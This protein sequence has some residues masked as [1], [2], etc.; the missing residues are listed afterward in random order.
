M[1]VAPSAIRTPNSRVRCDTLAAITPVTPASV[2]TIARPAKIDSS[3]A[4]RR[5]VASDSRARLLERLHV[6]DRHVGVERVHGVG[7][8]PASAGRIAG[9]AHH[10]LAAEAARHLRQRDE[11]LRN[12]PRS[13]AELPDVADDAD[14]R[15][16]VVAVVGRDARADRIAA[17]P[18]PRPSPIHT[19]TRCAS[20]MVEVR[21]RRAP[22]APECRASRSSGDWRRSRR[23]CG[24]RAASVVRPSM[25]N[26]VSLGFC[27]TI[28][29]AF[30]IAADVDARCRV[31]PLDERLVEPQLRVDVGILREVAE[32]RGR[33][34]TVGA[35][36]R[37]DALQPPETRQQQAGADEQH[38]DSATC[39]TTSPSCSRR[40]RPD[41]APRLPC[42]KR[43]QHVGAGRRA[44]TSPNSSPVTT[45]T[46]KR[47]E[48]HPRDRVPMASVRCVKRADEARQDA[49]R[50]PREAPGR[51]SAGHRRRAACS[52]PAAGARGVRG[53]RRA[54]RASR[55][56]GRGAASAP[57]SGSRRWRRPAAARA[58]SRRA[59]ANRMGRAPRR[60]RGRAPA[61]CARGSPSRRGR[62]AGSPA[63]SAAPP[64]PRRRRRPRRM[65]P[66]FSR[67][68]TRR[69]AERAAVARRCWRSAADRNGH[70]EVGM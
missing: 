64:W 28:G 19:T 2:T 70:A 44:G 46:P 15:P 41:A 48:Q 29:T 13:S 5:G 67:P 45:A 17:V 63:G 6:L 55:T 38:T 4:V 27:S 12:A 42:F 62:C 66:G 36:A 40:R 30:V 59:A 60:E 65:T 53:R 58:R 23:R 26:G 22:T 21:E 10:Q 32:R 50:G 37:V 39:A 25:S 57:A 33:Q 61:R 14:D 51:R 8:P 1:R 3:S 11:G 20:R 35:I 56:R 52:R 69:P 18:V 7:S 24:R 31:Q 49:E 47:E 43:G 9:A 16:P 34:H 68:N 54:P